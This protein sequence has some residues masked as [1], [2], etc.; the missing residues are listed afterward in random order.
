MLLFPLTSQFFSEN[1]NIESKNVNILSQKSANAITCKSEK[2]ENI[3]Y[4][5]S[6]Y[7]LIRYHQMHVDFFLPKVYTVLHLELKYR[8]LKYLRFIPLN[9]FNS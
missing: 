7:S 6:I 1:N 3:R 4:R 9:Q 8:Y 2:K 5:F